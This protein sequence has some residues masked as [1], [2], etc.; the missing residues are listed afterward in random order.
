M[1]FEKMAL[2]VVNT[3]AHA[4]MA[5]AKTEIETKVLG[6]WKNDGYDDKV[7]VAQAAY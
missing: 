7:P 5:T 4:A 2:N 1:K 6:F 3:K